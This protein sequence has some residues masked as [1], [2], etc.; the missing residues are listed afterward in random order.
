MR[1]RVTLSEPGD[2]GGFPA[3]RPPSRLHRI[4]RKANST[5]WYSSNGAGRF[6]LTAPVGTCY[7]ATDAYAAIREAS[8]L[9]PVT[10]KWILDREAREVRPPDPRA[11]LAATTRKAAGEF[12]M[13]TEL[14][15]IVPYDL[16]R[17]WAEA[18]HAAGFDGIRHE[19][20][21]D[22][23]ARPAGVS[24]FGPAGRSTGPDGKRRRLT[25]E[26]VLSAG[27]IVLEPPHSDA[28]IVLP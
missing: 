4:C 6:D 25:T 28:L 1:E 22:H 9:G 2:L 15:T 20:R 14:A 26:I 8:R 17:R 19:L 21:H 7:F 13:T 24:L 18:F 10:P 12:G 16:P 5:W 3:S 23:R 11:R 27:V